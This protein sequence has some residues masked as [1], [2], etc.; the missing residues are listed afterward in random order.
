MVNK[1]MIYENLAAS[2]NWAL[3]SDFDDDRGKTKFLLHD[4]RLP[5]TSSCPGFIPDAKGR[6][7]K[8]RGLFCAPEAKSVQRLEQLTSH[9][10]A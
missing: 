10:A 2:T 4:R 1:Y 6:S 9:L 5:G 8:A 3:R 7:R